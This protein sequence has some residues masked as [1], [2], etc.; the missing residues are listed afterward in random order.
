MA[1]WGQFGYKNWRLDPN[2][3]DP[4]PKL[5]LDPPSK[6]AGICEMINDEDLTH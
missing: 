4:R 1:Q 3:I 5:A 2:Q 6:G